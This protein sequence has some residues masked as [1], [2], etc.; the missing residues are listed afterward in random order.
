[1]KVL[2]SG[3]S[4]E[5][6]GSEIPRALLKYLNVIIPTVIVV[7]LLGNGNPV[8]CIRWFG[9][10]RS[11]NAKNDEIGSSQFLFPIVID[12][13]DPKLFPFPFGSRQKIENCQV[14]SVNESQ[15]KDRDQVLLGCYENGPICIIHAPLVMLA[16]P[17]FGL[18]EPKRYGDP[19]RVSID[20]MRIY[21]GCKPRA[22]G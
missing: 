11:D 18:I 19:A 6:H 22:T 1:M 3:L 20:V 9:E 10:A 4:L 14:L 13:F 2:S 12:P 7:D 21:I 8:A 16:S 17:S 5:D 15:G